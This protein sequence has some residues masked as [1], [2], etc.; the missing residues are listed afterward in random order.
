MKSFRGLNKN[1]QYYL[2]SMMFYYMAMNISSIFVN[3]YLWKA[4]HNIL[5]VTWYNM[6]YAIIIPITCII[7]GWIIKSRGPV[8]SY[9]LGIAIEVLFFA[10]LLYLK[11]DS[12]RYLW[13]IGSMKGIATAFWAMGMHTM[14]FDY[15]KQD[16][17]SLIFS[18]TNIF[19]KFSSL[20]GPLI[21]GIILMYIPSQRGYDI[22]FTSS[23]V[24]YLLAVIV[25]IKIEGIK[26][27]SRFKLSD[28]LFKKDKNWLL[29]NACYGFGNI[30]EIAFSFLINLLLFIQT[31]SEFS[32]GA[33]SSLA[34]VSSL[35]FIYFI[36]R[37][38]NRANRR[39]IYPICAVAVL[40]SVVGLVKSI[41]VASILF[42]VLMS[43]LFEPIISII[44]NS[45]CFE[46][47]QNDADV[48]N[49]RVEYI[50]AREIPTFIGRFIGLSVFILFSDIL[51]NLVLLKAT[52]LIMGSVYIW[53]WLMIRKIRNNRM[54]AAF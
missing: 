37:R 49:L 31:D 42:Y 53:N 18:Y 33:F 20:A 5:D 21:T 47:M 36:G 4:Q 24:L 52:I 23:L 43:S 10:F 14:S 40:L 12:I 35:F 6:Y 44:Q 22:I 11:T 17:Y 38:I 7:A 3:I 19:L 15:S 48:E 41:S 9:R 51:N 8:L 27:S 46:I 32:V 13:L 28:V 25:T 39:S 30:K 29:I 45:I 50:V 54:P 26:K 2:F 1:M 34:G 16:E